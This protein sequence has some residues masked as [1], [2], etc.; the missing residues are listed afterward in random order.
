M[1]GWPKIWKLPPG[2]HIGTTVPTKPYLD[3]TFSWRRN[4]G[5]AAA[6]AAITTDALSTNSKNVDKDQKSQTIKN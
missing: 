1:R 3:Y 2:T 5:S 4:F 6:A